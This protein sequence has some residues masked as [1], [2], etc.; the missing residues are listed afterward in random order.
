MIETQIKQPTYDTQCCWLPCCDTEVR[1]RIPEKE[2]ILL[3]ERTC[4]N[5][6]RLWTLATEM[7]QRS[8]NEWMWG[9]S[10]KLGRPTVPAVEDVLH[11]RD[12]DGWHDGL[13]PEEMFRIRRLIKAG[14]FRPGPFVP[15]E[16]AP[17]L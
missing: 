12:E 10:I 6:G 15:R 9:V 16:P 13:N 1:L 17:V 7:K 11:K 3:H 2:A 4:K 5:C 8:E 14:E